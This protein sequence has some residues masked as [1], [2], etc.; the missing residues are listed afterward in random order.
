MLQRKPQNRLGIN[1]IYEV[2]DHPWFKNYNFKALY[3]RR[4]DSPFIP[5]LGDNFDKK[6]CESPDKIGNDTLERYQKYY[7]HE[8]YSS[9]FRTYTYI[10]NV[11]EDLNIINKEQTTTTTTKDTSRKNTSA[12]SNSIIKGKIKISDNTPKINKV[13]VISIN[14]YSN[15]TLYSQKSTSRL[16]N[17]SSSKLVNSSTNKLVNSSTNSINKSLI[18]KDKNVYYKVSPIININKTPSSLVINNQ[19]LIK[20]FSKLK[21]N[22]PQDR[23]PSIDAKKTPVRKKMTHS[24]SLNMFYKFSKNSSISVNSTGSSSTSVNNLHKRSTST[25]NVKY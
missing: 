11:P 22:K 13:S 15:N 23:L 5:K 17:S 9:L 18:A 21:E 25:N 24:P 1:G 3:E 10:S 14:K 6:Y 20:S 4:I 7:L 8:E 12:S 2:K 19:S 16:L